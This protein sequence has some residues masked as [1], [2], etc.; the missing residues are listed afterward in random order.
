MEEQREEDHPVIAKQL[1][2]VPELDVGS[3]RNSCD[4]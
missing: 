3:E 4:A 1:F 2:V